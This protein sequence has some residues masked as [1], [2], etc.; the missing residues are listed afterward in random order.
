MR[1]I[2]LTA[3][4]LISCLAAPAVAKD[5]EVFVL[6]ALHGL[7]EQE[8]SFGYA[9]LERVIEEIKP[10]VLLLEVTPEELAGKL[11]TKGRPEYP[12]VV[13]PLLARSGIKAYAMEAAQPLYGELTGDA[14]ERWGEFTMNFPADETALTAHST[15]TSNVLLAHWKSVADTQ[16]E[17]TDALGRARAHLS[18]AMVAGTDPV[19]T[20]WDLAMVDAVK[21]AIAENSGKRILVLGSYRN[22]YMFVEQLGGTKGT[23]LI[24]MKSWLNANGFDRSGSAAR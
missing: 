19:Q 12:K 7:H 3:A 9:E 10:D 4:L 23:K 22:R 16:D 15:A 18:G 8:E 11:E 1:Y 5:S 21:S 6:G 17:A 13:W 20:R 24:D 2:G 14:G